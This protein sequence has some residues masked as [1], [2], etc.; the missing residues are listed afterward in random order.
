MFFQLHRNQVAQELSI[1]TS[2]LK[3]RVPISGPISTL[4]FSPAN[5]ARY[6]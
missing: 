5:H 1:D 2:L 4:Q 6:A 3:T